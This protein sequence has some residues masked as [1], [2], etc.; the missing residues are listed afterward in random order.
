MALFRYRLVNVFAADPLLAGTALSGN[1]LCVFEDASGLGVREMMALTRQFN[2]SETSFLLPPADPSTADARLR[3]FTPTHDPALAEMPFA[4]HPT[5]GSAYVLRAMLGSVDRVTFELPA[6]RVAVDAAGDVLTLTAPFEGE[7]RVRREELPEAKVAAMLGL[8]PEDL[9]GPPVW[10]DT[11]VEQFLVPLKTTAAVRKAAP[12]SADLEQWP[13]SLSG[14]CNAYVF[15][16]S[17]EAARGRRQ[18]MARF[19]IKA[20]GSGL[21]EDPGTG[22]ACANL[23]GWLLH[24][25]AQQPA[26]VQ[27]Q[28][29]ID[30]QRPCRLLLDVAD[31]RVRVGG[32]VVEVATGTVTLPDPQ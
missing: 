18:V 26:R 24:T 29:G 19:F 21:Y 3:I 28:Q 7:P 23:G 32:R 14:R 1:P 11:G 5:L 31:A 22:S 4:G 25:H 13:R 12:S 27:V 15:A 9:A 16:F 17:D 6:G 20:P 2:L 30:M 8:E 10:V